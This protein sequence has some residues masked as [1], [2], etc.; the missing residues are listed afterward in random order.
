[1][2]Q[3]YQPTSDKVAVRRLYDVIN[4]KPVV[5]ADSVAPESKDWWTFWWD[6]TNE[7]FKLWNETDSAW[8]VVITSTYSSIVNW[9]TAYTHSQ[10]VTGNPHAVTATEAGALALNGGNANVTI[11]IGS[12]ALTTTGLITA[13][14]VVVDNITIDAATIVSD[15]T[16]DIDAA[17]SIELNPSAL[18]DVNFFKTG[19]VGDHATDDGKKAYFY[20]EDGTYTDYFRFYINKYRI[21]TVSSTAGMQ[22]D[23]TGTLDL[24]AGANGDVKLFSNSID[25]SNRY[26]KQSGYIQT[27][28]NEVDITWQVNDDDDCFHLRRQNVYL[29]GF[30]VDMPL[31]VTG[32]ITAESLVVDNITIDAATIV[33]DTTLDIDAAGSIEL[34][35]S[36]LGDVQCFLASDVGE[37]RSFLIA[38]DVSSALEWVKFTV[39]SDG[40]FKLTRNATNDVL[41]FVVDMPLNVSGLSLGIVAKTATYTAL[42]SDDII[43]CG[44]GNETFTITLPTIATSSGKV[45]CI[46]NVGT[47]TISIDGSNAETID[48]TDTA[49]TLTSQYDSI[50]V[51][52]DG[53]EWWIL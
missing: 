29:L 9:D 27:A 3:I 36:A 21:G 8:E 32:A 44:A 1:M 46:K 25:G 26:F 2:R 39:A 28:A 50:R 15:T 10:I 14:S 7:L 33:S 47:G 24:N 11:D 34:N 52:C 30:T 17:G 41:G 16:L 38:G 12:E 31:E 51:V 43:T 5:I 13:G 53:T 48:G 49:K 22:L 42:I 18:G 6:T 35:P 20:R 19:D 23:A 4:Y 45:I 40:Y 37:N